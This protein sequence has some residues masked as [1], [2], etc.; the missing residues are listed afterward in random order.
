MGKWSWTRAPF[1]LISVGAAGIP[2]TAAIAVP[3]PFCQ[4]TQHHPTIGPVNDS[5]N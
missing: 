5:M 2:Q 1:G 3:K 4:T